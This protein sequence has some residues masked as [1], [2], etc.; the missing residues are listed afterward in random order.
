MEEETSKLKIIHINCYKLFLCNLEMK[1]IFEEANE[2]DIR[3]Y[4]S[5]PFLRFCMESIHI[6]FCLLA[7]NLISESKHE[8]YSIIKYLKKD[9]KDNE[10]GKTVLQMLSTSEFKNAWNK[11][12]ELRN[13][14]YAH[15]DK[16]AET[17]LEQVKLNQTE[18]NIITENLKKSIIELYKEKGIQLESFRM[19]R[20]KIE[21]KLKV[22]QEWKSNL[23]KESLEHIMKRNEVRL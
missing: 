9:L 5:D 12:K 17:I 19:G 15:N 4:N 3:N 22:I 11:V 16:E 18:R 20:P 21:L 23:V 14:C 8:A 10:T 13:K 7:N 6:H 2:D 1:Y